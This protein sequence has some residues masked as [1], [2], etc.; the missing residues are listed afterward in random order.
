MQRSSLCARRYWGKVRLWAVK[1]LRKPSASLSDGG[2]SKAAAPRNPSQS[3]PEFFHAK[4][5]DGGTKQG[6]VPVQ[7]NGPLR[8][9][10]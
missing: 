3:I 5:L 9:A 8:L 7:H 2:S 1:I 4:A 6:R 10:S